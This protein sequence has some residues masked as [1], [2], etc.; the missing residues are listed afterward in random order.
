[1]T[2]LFT[3]SVD[4]VEGA[5]LRGRIHLIS[6]DAVR[7]PQDATFPARLLAEAW[8]RAGEAGGDEGGRE[9]ASGLRLAPE[10]RELHACAAGRLVRV[11]E[12]GFLLAEDGC[13]VREPRRRAVDV[14]DL[15]GAGRD[16]VSGRVRT[17][18]DP[19]ALARRAAAIVTRYEVGPLRN[20]PAWSEVAAVD[21]EEWEPGLEEMATWNAPADLDY[22]R[23]WRLLAGRPLDGHPY[24]EVVVEVVDAGYLEHLGA[25]M[26]WS[27]GEPAGREGAVRIAE[28]WV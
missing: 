1:M 21:P 6:A 13:T 23:T 17:L 3:V 20:V 27:T 16:E 11:D 15:D 24:A 8:F 4:G 26:R 18:S 12:D 7:V 25:G 2:D 14:Y 9:R 5:V 10:L 22:W 19:D 28:R